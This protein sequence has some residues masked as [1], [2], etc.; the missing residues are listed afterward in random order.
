MNDPDANANEARLDGAD[1]LAGARSTAAID[2]KHAND[3]IAK[4]KY[5]NHLG[6]NSRRC[7]C[8][9]PCVCKDLLGCCDDDGIA[10]FFAAATPPTWINSS[11]LVI[12]LTIRHHSQ[13]LLTIMREGWM[14]LV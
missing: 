13:S 6:L 3:R 11:S 4:A 7:G 8:V 14:R 5:P 9:L 12:L 10:I 1:T 2:T